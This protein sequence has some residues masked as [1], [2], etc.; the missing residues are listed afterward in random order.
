MLIDYL[1]KSKNR[2]VEQT[3]FEVIT[4]EFYKN[5]V[6]MS[7]IASDDNYCSLKIRYQKGTRVIQERDLIFEDNPDPLVTIG[8]ALPTASPIP[9]SITSEIK[10]GDFQFENFLIKKKQTLQSKSWCKQ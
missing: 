5:T 2:N 8:P 4:E 10:W 6:P 3:V 9:P 1:N 7:V